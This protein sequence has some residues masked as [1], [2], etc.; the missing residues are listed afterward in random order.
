MKKVT[1]KDGQ[2]VIETCWLVAEEAAAYCGVSKS[3]FQ[4][5][6]HEI[7]AAGLNGRLFHT[8]VLDWWLGGCC[9]PPPREAAWRLRDAGS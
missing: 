2:V 7:P 9:G 4:R 1:L 6:R 3:T 5:Y 8:N